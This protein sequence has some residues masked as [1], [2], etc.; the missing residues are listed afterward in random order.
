MR[1]KNRKRTRKPLVIVVVI[2]IAAVLS[3]LIPLKFIAEDV[4]TVEVLWRDSE[5]FI[6]IGE[7]KAG[8]RGALPQILW[9]ELTA[10]ISFPPDDT[11]SNLLLFHIK[12]GTVQRH[13]VRGMH[14]TSLFPY[15][16]KIY[17]SIGVTVQTTGQP[18]GNGQEPR[19]RSST[20]RKE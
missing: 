6:T 10:L 7:T 3:F 13:E 15:H 14:G 16:N 5:A 18:Y 11:A 8:V 9:R 12:N 17:H 19:W 20:K 4:D 2:A 1:L